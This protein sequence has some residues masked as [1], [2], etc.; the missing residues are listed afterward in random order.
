MMTRRWLPVSV[1]L[2]NLVAMPAYGQQ[3]ARPIEQREMTARQLFAVGKYSEAL[4]IYGGLYAET[5]H[6]TYLRNIGR[7]YQ[8]M[9]EPDR[10]ISS[11]NE[12]LRQARDLPA[13]QRAIIDGYIREM[14][15][16]KRQ[17]AATPASHATA[18]APVTTDP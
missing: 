5:A 1:L 8:N 14:E 18:R 9:G 17:R 15:D 2:L 10:A 13:D 4:D 12:Y 6:P 3:A 7:C 16:L 11:F